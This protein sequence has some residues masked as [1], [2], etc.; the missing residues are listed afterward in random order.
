MKKPAALILAGD[1]I[2]SKIYLIRNKKVMLDFD[3]AELYGVDNKQM[4]RQVRRN[5][6]RFP[7]DFMFE[8]TKEELQNLRSQ[9]GTSSLPGGKAGW[10]GVRYLP[11]AFTEQGVA[12][13]SSILNSKQAILVNIQIIRI[14]TRMREILLTHKDILFKLEE[15]ENKVSSH[16]EQIQLIF[17]YLKQLVSPA[18]KPRKKIGYKTNGDPEII[19]EPKQRKYKNPNRRKK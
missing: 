5:A 15:L 7:M 19:S 8:L 3:L 16:D 6:E 14:F 17:Q 9:I 12:M 18:S 11:M 4:K 10:G 1:F 2:I 13:L